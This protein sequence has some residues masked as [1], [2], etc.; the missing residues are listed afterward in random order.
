[1]TLSQDTKI[2][3]QVLKSFDRAEELTILQIKH[4]TELSMIQV[5]FALQELKLAGRVTTAKVKGIVYWN[6]K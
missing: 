5:R 3:L 6:A 1:M 4:F 2:Q